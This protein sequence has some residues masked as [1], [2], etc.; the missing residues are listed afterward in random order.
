MAEQLSSDTSLAISVL[1]TDTVHEVKQKCSQITG[2]SVD[3]ISISFATK[4]LE[5]SQPLHNYGIASGEIS[6]V[7]LG[8]R[9]NTDQ[10]H[11]DVPGLDGPGC[12]LI[13]NFAGRVALRHCFAAIS[14]AKPYDKSS[15]IYVESKKVGYPDL[16]FHTIR[17]SCESHPYSSEEKEYGGFILYGWDDGEG[18]VKDDWYLNG[19][20]CKGAYLV[21]QGS[22]S[23]GIQRCKIF[24]PPPPGMIHGAVY[25]NVFGIGEDPCNAV[26]EGFSLRYGRYHWNSVTFN[27][28]SDAYH[29]AK[30][31]MA[32]L[33]A[34]CV[35]K[36]LDDWKQHS[37]VGKTYRVKELLK[38]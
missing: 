13:C 26:G 5:N 14:V 1:S 38:D 33:T 11:Y 10:D 37:V 34:K 27:A 18:S 24:N 6:L 16:Q 8:L 32:K 21:I 4:E 3:D 17:L 35:R 28:N 25:W 7:S 31:Q 30:K 15:T 20:H 12:T 2:I 29:D 22:N 23:P 36:I 9:E 19:K